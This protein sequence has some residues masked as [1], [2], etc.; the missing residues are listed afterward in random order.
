MIKVLLYILLVILLLIVLYAIII[1]IAGL[2]FNTNNC[3][4]LVILGCALN[5][6]KP[7]NSMYYRI[8]R[9]Y[10]YLLNNSKCKIIVSGG[11]TGRNTISEA[12]VMKELLINKGID[13]NRIILED[14][15]LTTIQNIEFVNKIIK[16]NSKVVLCSNNYHTFRAKLIA[17]CFGL[18][19][20]SI[21]C[22]SDILELINH[23]L[24]EE[25]FVVKDTISL[26]NKD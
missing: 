8:D 22:K 11:I 5:N 25:Y 21:V 23:L 15:S 14:K 17:R 19:F 6:N 7:I 20:K 2:S 1:L 12:E 13:Q 10:K 4:Y 16:T 26:K 9:A 24:I 3:D 18:K